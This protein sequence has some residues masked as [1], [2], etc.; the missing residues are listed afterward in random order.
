MDAVFEEK[1]MFIIVL[2][3]AFWLA[4]W[5]PAVEAGNSVAPA[6]G[7]FR[8][9]DETGQVH[10]GTEVPAGVDAQPLR[11]ETS[12]P[13]AGA[14]ALLPA[15][16]STA[17]S[18]ARSSTKSTNKSKSAAKTTTGKAA[19]KTSSAQAA[20]QE[21]ATQESA[22]Q[23]LATQDWATQTASVSVADVEKATKTTFAKATST[24]AAKKKRKPSAPSAAALERQRLSRRS[25][26]IE[27]KAKLRRIDNKFRS[28]FKGPEGERLRERQ[29]TWTMVKNEYCAPN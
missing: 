8:W 21:S 5:S 29:Q 12:A 10:Y 14:V 26:C 25:K 4:C 27:A 9:V 1:I 6:G 19:A 15:D 24:K 7:V 11:I 2:L 17:R 20:T 18:S 3:S 13:T 22:T 28:G 16:K 23:T